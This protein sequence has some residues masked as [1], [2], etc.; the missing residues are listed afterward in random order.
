MFVNSDPVIGLYETLKIYVAPL[1]I[2][3]TLAVIAWRVRGFVD[4][5]INN[6][7][8]H[9]KQD[10]SDAVKRNEES[11]EKIIKAEDEGHERIVEAIKENAENSNAMA[12]K[13]VEG[14]ER[15]VDAL[16]ASSD[17]LIDT[18]IALNVKK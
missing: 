10:I 5:L 8:A 4:T 2:I 11:L 17:R 9:I 12:K 18:L 16:K 7:L 14:H 13:A 15:I 3:T 6:H 1:S